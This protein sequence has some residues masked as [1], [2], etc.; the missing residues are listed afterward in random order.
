M[1]LQSTGRTKF[2]HTW[3]PRHIDVAF[4]TVQCPAA[5]AASAVPGTDMGP[6]KLAMLPLPVARSCSTASVRATSWCG[7]SRGNSSSR[8]EEARGD[9]AAG[10]EEPNTSSWAGPAGAGAVG[11]VEEARR[12]LKV[13]GSTRV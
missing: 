4:P 13:R 10:A 1:Q 6:V 12:S 5:R 2:V 3:D 8:E 7:A 9:G 11:V